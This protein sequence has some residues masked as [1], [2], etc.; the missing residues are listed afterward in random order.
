MRN[1]A[2]CV[3]SVEWMRG[4]KGDIFLGT[5][6]TKAK[7]LEAIDF[8]AS[9][10]EYTPTDLA[11]KKPF[12]NKACVVNITRWGKKPAMIFVHKILLDNGAAMAHIKYEK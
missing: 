10:G 11:E 5:F 1:K 12:N 8:W 6:S 9:D 4:K 7:A 3:W 2:K